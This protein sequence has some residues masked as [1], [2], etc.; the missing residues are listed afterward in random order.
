[1]KSIFGW[2]LYVSYKYPNSIWHHRIIFPMPP[3]SWLDTAN[4]LVY[5]QCA[6]KVWGS[7]SVLNPHQCVVCACFIQ[8]L[9]CCVQCAGWPTGKYTTKAYIHSCRHTYI[10]THTHQHTQ[11]HRRRHSTKSKQACY[12]CWS[13]RTEKTDLRGDFFYPFRGRL[14]VDCVAFHV[15]YLLS[16]RNG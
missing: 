12:L 11:R 13:V 14:C 2:H 15:M 1:M 4:P 9:L 16:T 5:Q 6:W 10:A 7:Q 3:L 8:C